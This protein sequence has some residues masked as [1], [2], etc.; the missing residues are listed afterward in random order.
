MTTDNDNQTGERFTG[1]GSEW[2]DSKLSTEDATVATAWV[3]QIVDKRVV[4]VC[5]RVH[6]LEGIGTGRDAGGEVL[7][8]ARVEIAGG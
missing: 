8:V 5:E 3:E 7:R 6:L 1:H 2:R 4:T